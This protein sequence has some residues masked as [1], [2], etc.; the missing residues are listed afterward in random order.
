MPSSN[1]RMISSKINLSSTFHKRV[2]SSG[3]RASCRGSTCS[4]GYRSPVPTHTV[5]VPQTSFRLFAGVSVHT[6][7]P[8]SPQALAQKV[9]SL[10]DMILRKVSASCYPGDASVVITFGPTVLVKYFDIGVT[11]PLRQFAKRLNSNYDAV[12]V[13]QNIRRLPTNLNLSLAG[14]SSG[15][16]VLPSAIVLGASSVSSGRYTSPNGTASIVV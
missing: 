1:M 3:L 5:G 4:V 10:L 7:L 6:V 11:T 15:P 9:P 12:E 16:V 14:T 2:R 8:G 13:L